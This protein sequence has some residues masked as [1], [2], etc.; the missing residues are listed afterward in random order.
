MKRVQ[1]GFTLIE[2]MIV[3]AII[4]ILAAI[5]IPAYQDYTI[6]AKVSELIGF[7]AAAKTSVSEFY[8][9]Q[10]HMPANASSAGIN[11]TATTQYLAS[12]AY[13]A[14]STTIAT[15]TLTSQAGL[16]GTAGGTSIVFTGTGGAN[17]VAWSCA[18]GGSM[19]AKYR[20]AN[21]R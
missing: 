4:G 10:G 16:G 20:P 14:T 15:L 3:V 5:A 11:T 13:A 17:G 2:L 1:Q 9:S 18:A 7:A 21:C 12:T 19:P 8:I 6:R